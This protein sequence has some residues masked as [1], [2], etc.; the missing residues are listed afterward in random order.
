[1]FRTTLFRVEC[2]AAGFTEPLV[3][4]VRARSPT[5]AARIVY[6]FWTREL[7][8]PVDCT[9]LTVQL[10]REPSGE[11]GVIYEVAC[12]EFYFTVRRGRVVPHAD[13]PE[14]AALTA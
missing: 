12:R 11:S 13:R 14:A 6:R 5:N 9:R 7:K 1:M 10:L 2:P 3:E 8:E 4:L